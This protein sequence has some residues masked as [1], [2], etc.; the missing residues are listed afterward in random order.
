MT[1]T[2]HEQTEVEQL[3]AE[4]KFAAEQKRELEHQ[5]TRN[6]CVPCD[7]PACNC[8]GW[9]Q[10]YGY[11]ERFKE[12]RDE[13]SDAGYIDNSTCNLPINGLRKLIAEVA[14]LRDD[15]ERYQWIR[16]NMTMDESESIVHWSADDSDFDAAIDRARGKA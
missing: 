15:A 10:R 6:G 2:S 5:L 14:A 3:R 7:V 11:I 9:H 16:R 1:I 13:L 4:L 12:L 8:G